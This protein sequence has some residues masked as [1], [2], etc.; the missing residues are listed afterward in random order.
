[1]IMLPL[2]HDPELC[3]MPHLGKRA[4]S[5]LDVVFFDPYEKFSINVALLICRGLMYKT[6]GMATQ[7]VRAQDTRDLLSLEA[8]TPVYR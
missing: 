2:L 6:H 5:R 1:M 7:T 3:E 8:S 4:D